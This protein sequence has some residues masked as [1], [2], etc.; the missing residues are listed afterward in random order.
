MGYHQAVIALR[1]KERVRPT[2]VVPPAAAPGPAR[3]PPQ[4]APQPCT[5]PAVEQL[6]RRV[7][8]MLEVPE[9]APQRDAHVTDDDAQRPPVRA[10]RLRTQGGLELVQALL[11]RP[12]R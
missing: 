9:P 7:V 10:S 6:E 1:D 11:P 4:N 2:L 12:A 5:D 8:A 3:T